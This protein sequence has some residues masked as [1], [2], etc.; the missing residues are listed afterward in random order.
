MPAISSWVSST[1][2]VVP[3]PALKT[4]LASVLASAAE[5]RS[6]SFSVNA[7]K[8]IVVAEV[9]PLRACSERLQA[10]AENRISVNLVP[11]RALSPMLTS[12]PVWLRAPVREEQLRKDSG[13]NSTI[14]LRNS[15][16]AREV[17]FA[18]ALVLTPIIVGMVVY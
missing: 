2:G 18:N 6:A 9:R 3:P 5:K 7:S 11:L 12:L 15:A 10:I 4:T 17:Q 1:V 14:K 13:A 8:Y 16:V